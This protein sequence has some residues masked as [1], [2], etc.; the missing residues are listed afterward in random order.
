GREGG[1]VGDEIGDGPVDLMAY[2]A[3][4]R[5]LR[6]ED[7]IRDQ[8]LVERPQVFQA[9][10]AATD[11]Q[12]VEPDRAVGLESIEQPDGCRDFSCGSVALDSHWDNR[13]RR[14]RPATGE[15]FEHVTDRGTGR[16]GDQRD[17]PGE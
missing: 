11:D 16:T 9:P 3:Y 14:D 2:G 4:H 12:R 15:Q 17:R 8:L 7:G 10:A 5:D 1:V 6:P 13:D